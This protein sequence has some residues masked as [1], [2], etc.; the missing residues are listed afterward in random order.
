M[1]VSYVVLVL[2]YV[3]VKIFY[4]INLCV[5]IKCELIR[6][7]EFIKLNCMY[8]IYKHVHYSNMYIYYILYNT[9]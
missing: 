3:C 6:A 9:Y 4:K 8:Y 7:N 5:F 2:F 1:H